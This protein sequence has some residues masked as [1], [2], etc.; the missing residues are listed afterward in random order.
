MTNTTTHHRADSYC[1]F[2]VDGLLYGI[3][4]EKVQEVLRTQPTTRVP[5]APGVVRGLINMRGHIVSTL[6]L[7]SALGLPAGSNVRQEMNV[8]VRSPEG[9]VS[10]LVDEICDVVR[11]DQADCEP[12]PGTLRRQQRLFLQCAYKLQQRLLLILDADRVAT[13]AH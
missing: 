11:V 12:I 13:V 10:L 8:I 1:T 5:L 3:E 9:P 2:L 6:S 7:R 4:V